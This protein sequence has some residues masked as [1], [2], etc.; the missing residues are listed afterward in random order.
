MSYFRDVLQA[1]HAPCQQQ[2]QLQSEALDRT[3]PTGV[4]H[5]LLLHN[6]RCKGCSAYV[7]HLRRLQT[8]C[9]L[10]GRQSIEQGEAMPPK[11]R[12]RL[13]TLDAQRSQQ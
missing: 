7:K 5:G 2:T 3:L 13:Q 10:V 11:I 9:G 1:M 4:R 12:E 6:F 8:L